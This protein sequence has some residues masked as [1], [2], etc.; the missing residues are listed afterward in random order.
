MDHSPQQQPQS[1]QSASPRF[2]YDPS[3]AL[4][5]EEPWYPLLYADMVRHGAARP[6]DQ[7]LGRALAWLSIGLGAMQLLAPRA[8]ARSTGLPDWPWLLRA[9]GARELVTGVGLLTQPKAP[10]WRWARVAGDTMDAALIGAAM[11]SPSSERRKLVATAAIAGGITALDM[12]AGTATRRKPSEET[13][14]GTQ[15]A[16]RV[17]KAI[18][19]NCA[20]PQCYAYWR[21][22]E[23]FRNFMQNIESVRVIDDRHSHWRAKGPGGTH[24]EW[25]AE[26][27]EDKPDRMIAWQ[28]VAGSQIEN[29]G[30]VRFEHAPG[31]KGTVVE[32]EMEYKPPAGAAGAA[33]ATLFGTAPSLQ[34]EGD[35][36]RFKQIMETGE[37]PSTKG[38]PHGP[39]TLKARLFNR[40]FEQ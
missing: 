15:G 38:Q 8:F 5:F 25:D 32:V 21:N 13:L 23:S 11:F 14:P 39:R 1:R 17:I 36:R 28:S 22:F 10:V 34:I 40:E 30:L 4:P 37:I 27:T 35:L 16:R 7:R 6:P 18:T 2:A 20:P 9:A 29:R 33:V 19:I 3:K 26:I 24:L 31:G 12:K